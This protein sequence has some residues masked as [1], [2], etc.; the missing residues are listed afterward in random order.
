MALLPGHK[1]S[2]EWNRERGA[3]SSTTGTCICGWDES[4]SS[5]SEVRFE[6]RMHIE[7]VK[8]RLAAS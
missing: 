7:T 8:K 6:Y 1:L 5:Q 4:A 2:T 3:E